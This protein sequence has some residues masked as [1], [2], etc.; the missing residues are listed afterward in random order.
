MANVGTLHVCNLPEQSTESTDVIYRVCLSEPQI[1][2]NCSCCWSMAVWAM[3]GQRGGERLVNRLHWDLVS[4]ALLQQCKFSLPI[5]LLNLGEADLENTQIRHS[6]TAWH[7]LCM[8]HSPFASQSTQYL[9]SSSF[10]ILVR[11]ARHFS[12]ISFCFSVTILLFPFMAI[13]MYQAWW[14][15]CNNFIKQLQFHSEIGKNCTGAVVLQGQSPCKGHLL[16]MRTHQSEFFGLHTRLPAAN[17]C[18]HGSQ[19]P[20]LAL[21]CELKL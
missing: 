4:R 7:T 20:A 21:W 2:C 9:L 5:T 16:P 10:S 18:S 14:K 17:S 8:H 1:T 19:F 3:P 6:M 12:W 13:S 15:K 11:I